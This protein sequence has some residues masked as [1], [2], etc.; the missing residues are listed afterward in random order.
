MQQLSYTIHVENNTLTVTYTR[1]ELSR[2]IR[3]PETMQQYGTHVNGRPTD[4]VTFAP[5]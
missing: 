2:N 5:S 3:G 4:T 1:V